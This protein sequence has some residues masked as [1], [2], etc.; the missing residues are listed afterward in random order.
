MIQKGNTR[1]NVDIYKIKSREEKRVH[2]SKKKE[3][4]KMNV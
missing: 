1:G 3:N 2:R 4:L